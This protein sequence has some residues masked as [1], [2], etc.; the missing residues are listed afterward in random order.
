M[1]YS[2]GNILVLVPLSR[3]KVCAKNDFYIFVP[4]DLGLLLFDLKI[5]F[6][7]QE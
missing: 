4:S 3:S 6:H 5:I 1:Q 7:C 2:L